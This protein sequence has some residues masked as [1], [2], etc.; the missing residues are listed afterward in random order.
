MWAM[1]NR[2]IVGIDFFRFGWILVK[3]FFLSL[4]RDLPN[5]KNLENFFRKLFKIQNI[6]YF[7]DFPILFFKY[8]ENYYGYRNGHLFVSKGTLEVIEKKYLEKKFWKM[9]VI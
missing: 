8:L 4:N 2:P 1:L 7:S 5:K 6:Q 9:K 3:I